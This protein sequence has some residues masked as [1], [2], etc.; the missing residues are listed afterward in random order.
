ME[1]RTFTIVLLLLYSMIVLVISLD[2]SSSYELRMNDQVISFKKNKEDLNTYCKKMLYLNFLFFI[3][4]HCIF[5]KYPNVKQLLFHS[6]G[7]IHI[8][9]MFFFAPL[10]FE[11]R[12]IWLTFAVESIP[13]YYH[14]IINL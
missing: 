13:K 7:I 9:M 10:T 12:L 14:E 8:I 1:L 3:L 2:T 11:T 4:S 5:Q 6:T